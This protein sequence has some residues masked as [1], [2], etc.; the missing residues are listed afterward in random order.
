MHAVME[1]G[2]P[3]AA[4]AAQYRVAVE[5]CKEKKKKIPF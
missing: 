1:S 3:V 5:F 2:R 4:H